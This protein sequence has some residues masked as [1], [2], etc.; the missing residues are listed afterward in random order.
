MSTLPF[1]SGHHT[2]IHAVEIDL[3]TMV[4]AFVVVGFKGGSGKVLIERTL[5]AV[6]DTVGIDIHENGPFPGA[7]PAGT[8]AGTLIA[9]HSC[10]RFGFGID[11]QSET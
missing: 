1:H 7:H 5:F 4:F 6:G 10:Q 8:D 11:R 2:Q 9:D 3:F